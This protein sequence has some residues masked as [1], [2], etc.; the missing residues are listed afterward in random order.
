MSAELPFDGELDDTGSPYP[1]AGMF[2]YE[3]IYDAQSDAISQLVEVGHN[4]GY[5]TF[6]GSCGTGKTAAALSAGINLQRDPNT[7]FE[8]TFALTGAKQ[9]LRAFEDDLER[10]NDHIRTQAR[11]VAR[12]LAKA[13]D[14]DNDTFTRQGRGTNESCRV[15]DVTWVHRA[16]IEAAGFDIEPFEPAMDGD[17]YRP[18]RALTLVGKAD[19]CSYVGAGRI[20]SEQIYNRCD[21]LREPVKNVIAANEAD[22][23]ANIL[24]QWVE[25]AKVDP[26]SAGTG[27]K[28]EPAD[29]PLETDEW[30]SPYAEQI[31]EDTNRQFCPFYAKHHQYRARERARTE[32]N[33][34]P[35]PPI[36]P[37][38]VERPHD[39]LVRASQRGL[40]PHTV[41]S[42]AMEHVDILIGNYQH[43]FD[44]L[45]V[46]AMTEEFLDGST[47]LICD[48]AHTMVDSVRDQLSETISRSALDA[49]ITELD[50]AID[51]I[52]GED[53]ASTEFTA[54]LERFGITRPRLV[55]LKSAFERVRDGLLDFTVEQLEE[56]YPTWR[57]TPDQ[58]AEPGETEQF[59]LRTPSLPEPDSFSEWLVDNELEDMLK[60]AANITTAV[61]SATTE[62]RQMLSLEEVDLNVDSVGRKLTRWIEEDHLQYLRTLE[63]RRRVEKP[64]QQT[65]CGW[66][67]EFTVTLRLNNC[68]PS[69]AIAR[70]INEFGGGVLMSATLSPQEVFEQEVGLDLIESG[71]DD[72][73]P[74]ARPRPVRHLRYG[75]NFPQEN[76]TTLRVMAQKFTSKYRG[77]YDASD[78]TLSPQFVDLAHDSVSQQSRTTRQEH[79]QTLKAVAKTTP[80]NV[81]VAMP[82]YHEAEWARDVLDP[83]TNE[84]LTKPVLLDTPSSNKETEELKSE[85]FEGSGKVL[86]TS[87]H[88]TLTQGVDYD[89]EKLDAAVVCGVPVASLDGPVSSAI[90]CAYED[91]FGEENG[92]EYAFIIPAVRKAR[93]AIGRVIRSEDDV[94]VRV[95]SDIRYTDKSRRDHVELLPDWLVEE[96]QTC[97]P[98][99]VDMALTQFWDSHQNE[100]VKTNSPTQ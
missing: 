83:D 19:M 98:D 58:I 65:L 97:S 53:D 28:A 77:I 29:S 36:L 46:S 76:R 62:V 99:M 32:G 10:I 91:S 41:M 17:M 69:A 42:A 27:S 63:L 73:D 64:E 15:E 72:I 38:G 40:C 85:F 20:D 59:S 79:A 23:A 88:G 71:S 80:G 13:S 95:F 11:I 82:N 37:Q 33:T 12:E 70:T 96:S 87:N 90:Q 74:D 50:D 35:T 6:E 30:I 4:G 60:D 49:A 51:R 7:R 100:S 56:E 22:D 68:I 47:F 18:I 55:G 93:Q 45:T 86:V 2:P 61:A 16:E 84:Q 66:E 39:L 25:N 52:D 94:G 89:G 48:E 54:A 3:S 57:E 1:W 5:A 21:T 31:P 92:F 43:A 8:T 24:K 75:L 34:Q 44:P 81:L 78:E 9:Q 14:G 26:G 67:E